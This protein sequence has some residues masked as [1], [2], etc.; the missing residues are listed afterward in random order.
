M[1]ANKRISAKVGVAVRFDS[2]TYEFIMTVIRAYK[3]VRT[4]RKVRVQGA[5]DRM[6]PSNAFGIGARTLKINVSLNTGFNVFRC[7]FVSN[8]FFFSGK[9]KTFTYGS[10]VPLM[11]KPGNSSAW[12]TVTAS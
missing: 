2:S 9:R 6:D 5:Y 12:M 8:F 4:V 1:G 10:D 7:T 11:S 3:H